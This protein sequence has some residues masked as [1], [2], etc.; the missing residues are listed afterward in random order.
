MAIGGIDV[1]VLAFYMAGVVAIGFWVGRG[2]RDLQSYLLGGRDLPWWAILGSLVATETSTATFLSVPGIAYAREH[3]DLRFLQLALGYIVGRCV[4]AVVLLPWFFRGE[5]YTAYEVL[6]ERFGGATKATASAIFLVTRNLGDGLRL[7]LTAIA[8]REVVGFSLPACIVII[9]LAT[10]LYTVFGGMKS[11]VWND[12]VQFVVYMAGGVLALLVI[13]YRLPGGWDEL[14]AFGTAHDKFRLLDFHWELAD[15]YTFWAAVVGG[16]F[17]TLG[18]HGTDQMM[19]QRYLCARN[20]RDA[21]RALVAS[22]LVVFVQFALFLFLGVA[23][24]SY[25]DRFAPDVQ[26]KKPDYVFATFIV[27]ELAPN[28]GLIGLLLAAV[29]AAAMS[30]LSSSLNSSASAAVADF[31]LPWRRKQLSAQHQVDVSRLMTVVFGAVQIGVAIGADRLSSSVVQD[32]LAIA[33]FAAGLL[34]GIFFLGVLTRRV[35]QT[36]AL[37]GLIAGLIALLE[38]K[39]VAPTF[40]L[41]VAWPWFALIGAVTTFSVGYVASF[42]AERRHSPSHDERFS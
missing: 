3:G 8:L 37:I 17:L 21:G 33:S 5:L 28:V 38:A 20:Q 9:G 36:A 16:M 32:A 6:H 12:C 42:A 14:I 24:A 26:F 1:A 39:F 11:V 18:T 7:Y 27:R 41:K 19:V 4:I 30:T 34:L 40:G 31:Y 13:G 15:A 10:I 35:G 2:Q 23:L 22:G 29:F 25:Y